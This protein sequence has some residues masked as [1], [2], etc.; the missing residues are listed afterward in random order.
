MCAGCRGF[1][2]THPLRGAT[3]AR[4]RIFFLTKFQSTHPLRGATP[5][6]PVTS[7]TAGYFN[8]RTPCGVRP[9]VE[10]DSTFK[11][12]FQSTHPLRGA[13]APHDVVPR[14]EAISIHAPLAGCDPVG[15]RLTIHLRNFNPRTPCGV[16]RRST[17]SQGRTR[18]FNPRT[19]CGVRPAPQHRRPWASDFNPRT[20]CGVRR[21]QPTWVQSPSYFNPRTPCGV[22]LATLTL[23]SGGFEF[24][25][26]HPLRGAT[27][28]RR[29][30]DINSRISIHAPLAGCDMALPPQ[31][32]KTKRFQSTH[33][34]RGATSAPAWTAWK[35]RFQS[36][37]PLRGATMP[38]PDAPEE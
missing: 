12:L 23:D 34:L 11:A 10:C 1:Q 14:V 37:H 30:A 25:S 2:S 35:K 9:V 26:T 36:T 16:R 15:S 6:T 28:P 4:G 24:Q 18:Y 27:L 22:R 8:P 17:R 21:H 33:P 38:L 3:R 7:G 32:Q 19:P 13:T 31:P 5:A 29:R 20:P